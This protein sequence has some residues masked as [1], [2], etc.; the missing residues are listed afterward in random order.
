MEVAAM[1]KASGLYN[2]V[3]VQSISKYELLKLFN[4]YLR[5]GQVKINPVEG[6][7][8]NKSLKRTRFEFDYLIP[9]YEV[10]VAELAQWIKT[11][12]ELYPH[13]DIKNSGVGI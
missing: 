1:A 2:T 6:V 3:P 5:N 13:Y 7:T 10:M 11:H 9:D 4:Y 8:A 12:K